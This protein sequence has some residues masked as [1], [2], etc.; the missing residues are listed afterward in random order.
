MKVAPKYYKPLLGIMSAKNDAKYW[1]K[2]LEYY[3]KGRLRDTL[4]NTI[5]Y[6]D[7]YALKRNKDHDS[8]MIPHG[9]TVLH[10]S[11]REGYIQVL[12]PFV[13]LGE[14][15]MTPL[16]RQ[17]NEINFSVLTTS[18][19]RLRGNEL[20]FSFKTPMEACEPGKIYDVFHEICIQADYYD[21]IFVDELGAQRFKEPEVKPFSPGQQKTAWKIFR[22]ILTECDA[23]ISY[24][25]DERSFAVGLDAAI[26]TLMKLDCVLA[27]QGKLRSDIEKQI[28]T[29]LQK[30]QLS[31]AEK[32]NEVMDGIHKLRDNYTQERFLASLY[33]P[34]F[35]ISVRTPVT[36]ARVQEVL[37]NDCVNSEKELA[38]G[39]QISGLYFLMFGIYNLLYRYSPPVKIEEALNHALKKVSGKKWPDAAQ[40]LL[41]HIQKIMALTK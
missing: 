18:Q 14:G 29:G 41:G 34:H 2:A 7:P 28:S 5:N 33:I 8:I 15:N 24:L 26:M 4:H 40:I 11:V 12:A 39:R 31:D 19:I 6:C 38:H 36:L 17:V 30:G 23:Y 20:F 16:L 3:E 22:D 10:V 9:S 25:Q 13:K 1:N 21:D 37:R 35:F 32:L 27:P